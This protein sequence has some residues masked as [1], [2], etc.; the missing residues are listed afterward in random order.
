MKT[1]TD[2][3]IFYND[4]EI[5]NFLEALKRHMQVRSPF[6]PDML[7]DAIMLPGLALKYLMKILGS[8]FHTMGLDQADVQRLICGNLVGGPINVFHWW[9]VHVVYTYIY[10]HI[11]L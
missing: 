8:V 7:M 6:S 9:W 5:E 10:N 2:W 3:L 1:L 11:G 4:L